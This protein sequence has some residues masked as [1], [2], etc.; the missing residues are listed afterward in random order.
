LAAQRVEVFRL[1]FD[2]TQVDHARTDQRPRSSS[3][4]WFFQ[5]AQVDWNSTAE[6]TVEFQLEEEMAY[7]QK[8]RTSGC[9]QAAQRQGEP[10]RHKHVA[11]QGAQGKE[12]NAHIGMPC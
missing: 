11:E 6:L 4:Q 1:L 12:Q 7:K 5:T 2:V 8:R 10:Q 3:I 9:F